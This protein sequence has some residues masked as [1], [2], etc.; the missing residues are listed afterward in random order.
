MT[1]NKK[2]ENIIAEEA[3]QTTTRIVVSMAVCGLLGLIFGG[4]AGGVAGAEIG[5]LLSS[6]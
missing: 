6:S 3:I 2:P 5:A 4:P 1:K